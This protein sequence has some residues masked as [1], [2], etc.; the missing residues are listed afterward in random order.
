MNN[1][2]KQN[3]GYSLVELSV[4]ILIIAIIF[5][6]L[7]KYY[8]RQ[9]NITQRIVIPSNTEN[10]DNALVGFAYSHGRLPFADSNGN[11]FENVGSLRGTIPEKTLGMA[12]KPLN[13]KKIPLVYS[14]YSKPNTTDPTMDASLG[15]SSDRLYALLPPVPASPRTVVLTPLNQSNTIDFCFALRNAANVTTNETPYLHVTRPTPLPSYS[16]NVAYVIVDVGNGDA[17]GDG[18]LLDGLNVSGVNFEVAEKAQSVT[19]DDKVNSMEFSELFGSL[20][21]G[22]VISAALHAHDNVVIAADMMHT[23]F[24]DYSALLG[25]AEDLADV[26]VLLADAAIAQAAAAIADTVSA[27]ATAVAETLIPGLQGKGAAGAAIITA[28]AV[29]TAASTVAAVLSRDTA[30]E[31]RDEIRKAN[32]CFSSGSSCDVGTGRFISR[33]LALISVIRTNAV[34]ADREGL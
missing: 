9:Q 12:E 19:Y 11:G 8:P 26:G 23:S 21:C 33:A 17:D 20:A 30:I 4:V 3:K 24:I 27:A 16:R 10:I 7:Y 6:L 14:L 25:I 1:N 15:V 34:R 22:S 29:T 5:S 31:A 18:N 28:G 32:S 2:L 13:M